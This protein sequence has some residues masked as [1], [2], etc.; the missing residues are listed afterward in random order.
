[1]QKK[2]KKKNSDFKVKTYWFLGVEY[3]QLSPAGLVSTPQ[4]MLARVLKV[5]LGKETPSHQQYFA[6]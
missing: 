5:R 2:E 6:Y 4:R 3:P 1:M